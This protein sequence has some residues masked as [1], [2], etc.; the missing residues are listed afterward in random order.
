[1]RLF[2]TVLLLAYPQESD[3]ES[4][5]ALIQRL[6]SDSFETAVRAADA[7]VLRDRE[8]IPALEK[9]LKSDHP[10]VRRWAERILAEIRAFGERMKV[11]LE[12]LGSTDD[13][14]REEA[15]KELR[16][17]GARTI[18]YLKSAES[19][20]NRN[21]RRRAE[22]LLGELGV[23]SG[24]RY[25]FRLGGK[26]NLV[27]RGGGAQNTEDAVKRALTWLARHQSKDGSWKPTAYGDECGKT[28]AGGTCAPN[29]GNEEV[30]AGVTGLALLAFLGAGYSHLTKEHGFGDTVRRGLRWILTNQDQESCIGSRK[31]D[32]YMY[33]HLLCAFALIEAYGLT[34]SEL[35]KD[36]AQK[37]LDFVIASQNPGKGWRYS[38]KCGDNDSSVTGWA[39]QV[40]RAA[41]ISG[42]P[43]PR[44]ASLGVRAWFD[45][46]TDDDYNRVGYTTKGTGKVYI[47][48]KNEQFHHHE[49]LTAMGMVSRL[50]LDRNLA[51]PRLKAGAELLV[52]D[53]PQWEGNDVDFYYWHHGTMALFHYDGPSGPIWARWNKA[54]KDA[55]I[56]N[57]NIVG[58]KTGS[59]EPV[60]RWSFEGG[61]VYA[62]AL[63]AMTLEV[64]YRYPK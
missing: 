30:E 31:L 2:L 26:R 27:A 33:G 24:G 20:D 55:L 28:E 25:G 50:Y 54:M 61:R 15:E 17:L 1:M 12:R 52:R 19:S 40:L 39:A 64:Y 23:G 56:A 44:S 60:D 36:P 5:E 21:L 13:E 16:K 29:P 57:Q 42:L 37:A 41:V 18:P 45:E 4:I 58:C 46:V 11:L 59:W 9:A 8:A 22:K 7:L 6:G 47:P 53:L 38:F 51:D 34:G 48:T 62:T 10:D 63:N 43:F 32:K 14:V 49:T 3:D 35:F